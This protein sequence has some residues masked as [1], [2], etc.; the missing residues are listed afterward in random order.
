MTDE[1]LLNEVNRV[2]R[3]LAQIRQLVSDAVNYIRGAEK[4]VPEFMPRFFLV[5][6]VSAALA[7][8]LSAQPKKKKILAIGAVAVA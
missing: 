2:A 6:A 5:L 7:S 4:E 8:T 1:S 3:E